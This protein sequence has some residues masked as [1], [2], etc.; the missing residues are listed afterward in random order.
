MAFQLMELKELARTKNRLNPETGK[1]S[2]KCW[3]CNL[4]WEILVDLALLLGHYEAD[5]T[6]PELKRWAKKALATVRF[7][8]AKRI[9]QSPKGGNTLSR[10]EE[11]EP[12]EP[13]LFPRLVGVDPPKGRVAQLRKLIKEAS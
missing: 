10:Q 8:E 6:D 4:S 7:Y 9:T 2:L 1:W 5:V 13:P 12:P 3:S 11:P